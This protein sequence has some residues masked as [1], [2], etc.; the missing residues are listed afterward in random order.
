MD[1]PIPDGWSE[2]IPF[3]V[4]LKQQYRNGHRL[5][6]S[7]YNESQGEVIHLVFN[8][9]NQ[10]KNKWY[11]VVTDLDKKTHRETKWYRKAIP[12]AENEI[13]TIW[14]G[15]SGRAI[16]KSETESGLGR[17]VEKDARKALCEY[18]ETNP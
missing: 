15:S 6:E 12:F 5:H 4:K 8:N 2:K 13:V 18:M 3:N 7:F 9:R 17:D 1:E 16:F 10:Y 14:S 11:V